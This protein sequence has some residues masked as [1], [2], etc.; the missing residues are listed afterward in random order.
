MDGRWRW[1]KSWLGKGWTYLP[2]RF[3]FRQKMENVPFPYFVTLAGLALPALWGFSCPCGA[4]GFALCPL[5]LWLCPLW[6]LLL[7][8]VA[9]GLWLLWDNFVP[10][11][12]D[13]AHIIFYPFPLSL[14]PFLPFVPPTAHIHILKKIV[15]STHRANYNTQ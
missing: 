2:L 11:V 8:A 3:S 7:F 1:K 15:D 13:S 5:W 4:V 6:G 12:T 14:C 10:A 9:V